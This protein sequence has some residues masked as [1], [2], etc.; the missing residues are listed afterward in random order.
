MSQWDYNDHEVNLMTKTFPVVIEQD[1]TGYFIVTCP[2]LEGCYSQGKTLDE[3]ISNIKEA[4]E[5]ALE[6][7]DR[8]S[9]PREGAIISQ[10]VIS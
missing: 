8:D 5:L 9:L 3:A 6:D 4:I 2:I 7:V 1:E 10:V